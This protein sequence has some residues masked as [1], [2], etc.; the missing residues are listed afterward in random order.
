LHRDSKAENLCSLLLD[1]GSKVLPLEVASRLRGR[2]PLLLAVRLREREPL[3]EIASG[4]R[5][6]L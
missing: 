2:K 6:I 5:V 4:P 3:P 1:Y